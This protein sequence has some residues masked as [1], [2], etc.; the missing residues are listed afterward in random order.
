MTVRTVKRRGERR[1]VIDILYTNSSGE[2]VR[3]RRDAEVQMMASAKSEERRRLALLAQ[4][5]RPFEG[6]EESEATTATSETSPREDC[7]TIR[8]AGKEYFATYGVTRLKPSTRRG[9]EVVF[10]SLVL[11]RIGELT[12]V[13]LD[14]LTMRSLDLELVKRGLSPS[15]RRQMQSVVRSLSRWAVESGYLDAMPKFPKLPHAGGKH[16]NKLTRDQVGKIVEHTSP[17]HRLIILLA[18]YAGLRAGEVRGLKWRDV[19][20]GREI[21]IVRRSR[22]YGTEAAP[23]SGHERVIPLHPK[24]IEALRV[25]PGKQA[26]HY[27]TGPTPGEPWP[28]HRPYGAFRSACTRAGIHGFRLHDLRHAF[29]TELFHSGSSAPVVQK[30]AG[31]EHLST[32]QRYAHTEFPELVSAVARINW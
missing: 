26:E 8:E 16:A 2:R 23:K 1:F 10:S 3:F 20:L 24:L 19:D 9:Y 31:H 32:T 27:V 25:V 7:M 30:L 4:T 5:G 15:S 22:C 28:E 12:L 6:P 11:P 21:L 13:Q 18:T 14:A 17:Q 29:V